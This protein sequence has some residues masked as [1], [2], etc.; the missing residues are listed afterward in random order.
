MGHK[1]LKSITLPGLPD[2]YD[3]TKYDDLLNIIKITDA[4]TTMGEINTALTAIST[5]GNHA[6]FDISALKAGMRLCTVFIDSGEYRVTDIAT[7]FI[8]TGTYNSSDKLATIVASG[9]QQHVLYVG[10]DGMFYVD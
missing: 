1:N 4:N 5:A 2:V 7:G 10:D 3:V 9:S 6:I 8:K